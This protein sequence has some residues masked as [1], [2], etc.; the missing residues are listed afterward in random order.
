MLQEIVGFP[1]PRYIYSKFMKEKNWQLM[2]L[3]ATCSIC[4]YVGYIIIVE[5][6]L[7]L[8]PVS[9]PHPAQQIKTCDQD[10]SLNALFW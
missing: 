7:S 8:V 2:S 1:R 3:L 10:V 6:K 9:L 4:I 5:F